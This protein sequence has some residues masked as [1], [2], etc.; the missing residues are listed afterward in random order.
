MTKINEKE[1]GVG[2]FKKTPDFQQWQ[3]SRE[4]YFAEGCGGGQLVSVLA[5]YSDNPSSNPANAYSF[6]C[7]ICFWK[8]R[9]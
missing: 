7:K 6:F 2:P 9:K 5:F 3:W 1:A 4:V 8:E